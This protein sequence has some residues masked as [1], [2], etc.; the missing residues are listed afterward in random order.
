[1]RL[2]RPRLF[3]VTALGC[4]VCWGCGPA[5]SGR[6]PDAIP[7]K[8]KVTYKGEPV[9][10]GSITFEPEFGRDAHAQIQSDGSFVLTTYKDADGAVPGH[11]RVAVSGTG[12]KSPKDALAKKWASV[13][14]SGLEA[15]VDAEHAELLI[16]LK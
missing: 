8:G 3:V 1:M 16:N 9:T 11:H 2:V 14:S 6:M 13:S 15:D 5:G 7:V 12:I 10:K 4:G